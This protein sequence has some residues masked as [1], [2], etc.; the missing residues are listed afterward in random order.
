MKKIIAGCLALTMAFAFAGCSDSDSSQASVSETSSVV[1]TE[2]STVTT[3]AETTAAT[4]SAPEEQTSSNESADK[5]VFTGNGYTLNI[6]ETKWKNSSDA[7]D[8]ISKQ[9]EQADTGLNIDADQLSS[10]IDCIFV[11][12]DDNITNFNV[13]TQPSTFTEDAD[14]SVLD[15]SIKAQ[16]ENVNGCS[17]VGSE[18][19]SINGYKALKT[20]VETSADVFGYDETITQYI[21]FKNGKQFVVTYTTLKDSDKNI[22]ADFDKVLESFKITD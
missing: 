16:Y 15:E 11:S 12:T 19:V 17:Y 7:T 5:N 20:S 6:D 14:Y 21:F 18:T 4:T 10:M 8:S 1:T 2:T 22:N 13:V 3:T 9:S